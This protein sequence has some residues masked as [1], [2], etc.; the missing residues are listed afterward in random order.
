MTVDADT[1]RRSVLTI[2]RRTLKGVPRARSTVAVL[3]VLSVLT[4][5]LETVALYL[6]GRMAVSITEPD[7]GIGVT[8]LT[9]E[10]LYIGFGTAAL[11][12]LVLLV[13]LV[14]LAYPI[15]RL[16]S[17]LSAAAL[18]KHRVTI[19]AAY[20]G[21]SWTSKDQHREGKLQ[22][23]T[24]EYCRR[25]EVIVQQ[26]L[27]V[28]VAGS[29]LS[30]LLL[31]ALLAA[32]LLS[33]VCGV[34]FAVITLP[35]RPALRNVRQR[36]TRFAEADASIMSEVA[37]TARMAREIETFDVGQEVA[38]DLAGA[39]AA[40]GGLMISMRTLSKLVPVLFSYAA[41]A[42][43]LGLLTAVH[44][45][46]LGDAGIIGAV[47]LML[48]RALGYIRQVQAGIQF[49]NEYG[50]YADAFDEEVA[51][52][53]PRPRG[54]APSR[55]TTAGS[56][57]LQQLSFAYDLEVGPLLL[58]RVSIS[59]PPGAA[60]G[61]VGESGAGKSTLAQLLVGLRQPTDGRILLGGIPTDELDRSAW[62]RLVH[63]VP[64][65]NQLISGTIR[66]NVAFF[67]RTF[68]D[69]QV[70]KAL[71]DANLADLLNQLPL[72]L[73]TPIGPGQAELSGGQRQRLGIARAL[74]GDPSILVLD[75]PTSA[76]DARSEE[77]VHDAL[78]R[79]KGRV[80]I[81]LVAHKRSSLQLCD[82]GWLVAGGV[83]TVLDADQIRSSVF[84][85]RA[86]PA[87]GPKDL[88][89]VEERV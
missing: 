55:T 43:V 56:V 33:A 10:P 9:A 64:Q 2:A 69:E 42:C 75:E 45:V 65:D 6:I 62:S 61:I 31:G 25:Q 46:D 3:L 40:A 13:A 14:G 63:Y 67:R 84:A 34:T 85:D 26:V 59:V 17:R 24:G 88:P 19:L 77:L 5:V 29:S 4:G 86:A 81:L 48:V 41:L 60:V 66:D 58:D 44:A 27:T 8:M 70:L 47:L 39:A 11:A 80:T 18:V 38:E 16:A 22:E 73:D 72:G 57:E 15:A 1:G 68:D 35:L 28:L 49:V 21:A 54:D 78:E 37:Q 7:S 79:L 74:L 71:A 30:I 52:L 53:R 32:P 36:S 83:V 20:L 51:K 76:L 23:L 12:V 89:V 50:P 82:T 87:G